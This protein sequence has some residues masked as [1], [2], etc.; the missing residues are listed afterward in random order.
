MRSPGSGC[1]QV[2]T[3]GIMECGSVV[4]VICIGCGWHLDGSVLSRVS[5]SISLRI[6]SP[7]CFLSSVSSCLSFVSLSLS[8]SLS[9]FLSLWS[10]AYLCSVSS[11]L[12]SDPSLSLLFCPWPCLYLSIHQSVYVFIHAVYY[13]DVAVF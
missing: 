9:S 5:L 13:L 11:I 3:I 12:F 8:L 10:S 4:D 7:C 1:N 2:L 6:F